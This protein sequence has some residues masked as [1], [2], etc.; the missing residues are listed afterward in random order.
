MQPRDQKFSICS[1]DVALLTHC[2]VVILIFHQSFWNL[3]VPAWKYFFSFYFSPRW[4]ANVQRL[5]TRPSRTCSQ[6]YLS[7]SFYTLEPQNMSPIGFCSCTPKVNLKTF[8]V[9]SESWARSSNVTSAG[10]GPAMIKFTHERMKH[11]TKLIIIK[12]IQPMPLTLWW[13]SS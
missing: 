9:F 13:T 5:Q 1:W 2:N 7:I 11:P 6:S 10:S 12:I 3:T 8:Q 4:I